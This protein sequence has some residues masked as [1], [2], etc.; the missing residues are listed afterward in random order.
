MSQVANSITSHEALAV[1]VDV[2]GTKIAAGVVDARGNVRGR[3]KLATDTATPDATLHSIAEAVRAVL[4]EAGVTAE[5]INGV[6]LGIPGKVDPRTGTSLLA[7]NLG[8]RDVPVMRLLS[9]E[10]KLPCVVENDVSVA[11]LGES[12]YGAGRGV[13]SVVYL[14]L[15]TGIAARA[16]LNGR[17]IR[18]SSGLAGEIGHVIVQPGGPRCACGAYGCLEAVA[19]GPA[20]ARNAEAA[21]MAGEASSLGEVLASGQPLTAEHVFE[22]AAKDDSLAVCV[23]ADAGAHIAYALYLLSMMFDT[24]I[25]VLGGGMASAGAHGEPF[26]A[27]IRAGVARW[28][29]QSPVFRE[30]RASA[31]IRLTALGR[32]AGILGA[33]ALIA[34]PVGGEVIAHE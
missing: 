31:N 12:T 8:W 11:A 5:H 20:L 26:I 14:S 3:V 4:H 10:M 18:G 28:C 29:E 24:E 21:I 23:L 2:G 19:A 9:N 1:G 22:A 25:V 13:A 30:T 34:V 7:V 32:D 17:V 15:G 33:A 16:V 27:A 6:G